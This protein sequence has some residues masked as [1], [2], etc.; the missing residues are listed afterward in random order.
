MKKTS[1]IIL[2]IFLANL[3]NAQSFKKDNKAHRKEQNA[4]FKDPKE[5]P[6]TKED[7]ATFKKL[8]Y[9]PL[10]EVYKVTAKLTVNPN[11]QLF[12]M[13]TS[14]DRLPTYS[15]YG[16]LTFEVN[17]EQLSLQVYQNQQFLSTEGYEDYLFV[18]FA[19]ETNG[20]ETYGG[21]RYLDFRMPKT[22]EVEIDFNKAYNPYCAYSDRYSCPKVPETNQL[23]IRIEAGVLNMDH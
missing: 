16:E 1:L 22:E 8:E 15:T 10:N 9:F 4:Q 14:T 21:G 7:L 23:M 3:S 2:F 19:D 6:L 17:G 5:S 13:I 11:P 12:K 18:P 20:D